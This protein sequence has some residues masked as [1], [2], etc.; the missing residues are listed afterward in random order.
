MQDALSLKKVLLL[1]SFV[2][3]SF[4]FN[5]A[6]F[7]GLGASVTLVTGQPAN[8]NPSE[9]TQLEITLANNNEA[10]PITAVAW[11]LYNCYSCHCGD[12]RWFSADL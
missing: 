1:L 11:N 5:T 7:A 3:C 12:I 9:I 10:A 6:A 8:I 2:V 4:F